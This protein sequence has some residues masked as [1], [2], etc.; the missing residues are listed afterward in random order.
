MGVEPEALGV[1]TASQAFEDADLDH[2]GRLSYVGRCRLPYD[3]TACASPATAW[4]CMALCLTVAAWTSSSGGSLPRIRRL[5]AAPQE[6]RSPRRR[7]CHRLLSMVLIEQRRRAV[8][9]PAVEWGCRH[10]PRPWRRDVPG[11]RLSRHRRSRLQL[12]LLQFL[13]PLLRHRPLMMTMATT[14]T[15]LSRCGCFLGCQATACTKCWN[16][17]RA[18]PTRLV[19]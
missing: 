12:F 4:C 18:T 8:R 1:A 3:F 15:A 5:A 7:L 2:D 11:P 16:T 9:E 19:F 6:I 13:R 14:P 17:L 10:L